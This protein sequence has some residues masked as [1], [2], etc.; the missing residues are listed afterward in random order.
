MNA[1]DEDVDVDLSDDGYSSPLSSLLLIQALRIL[2]L[3]I[4]RRPWSLGNSKT[5]QNIRKDWH[6]GGKTFIYIYLLSADRLHSHL[7]QAKSKKSRRK[8]TVAFYWGQIEFSMNLKASTP[9]CHQDSAVRRALRV[10]RQRQGPARPQSLLPT[11]S[12]QGY[13]AHKQLRPPKT[14]R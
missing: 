10:L 6:G 14:L 9:M 3:C 7:S 4:F 11:I 1:N 2:L 13:L 5:F 12:V 8:A